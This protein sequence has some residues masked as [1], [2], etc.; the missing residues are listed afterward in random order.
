MRFATW[1]A[2]LSRDGPGLLLRDILS[3]K[4]PEV[5]AVVQGLLNIRP[6]VV[7]LTRVDHDLNGIAL[8]ALASRLAQ[9]GLEYPY[10]LA[11]AQNRGLPSGL[12]LD[13][14]GR[15][16]DPDDAHGYGRFSGDGAMA[17]LSRWPL[18]E[19]RDFSHFLWADMPDARL[20]TVPVAARA[21]HRLSSSAH[22]IVPVLLPDGGALHLL[23]WAATPPLFGARNPD[24]NHD[25]TAFWLHLLEGRLPM[26]PP[27]APFVLIGLP[28]LAPG[29]GDPSALRA[30]AV[31]PA[32]HPPAPGA[33]AMLAS[34]PAPLSLI[35]P[36]ADLHVTASGLHP[37]AAR[38]RMVWMTV[39]V[40]P[41]PP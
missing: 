28:N 15:R 17:V 40:D 1:N 2:D 26:A 3:G 38:H 13:G 30:L 39:T 27:S 35:Q 16:G 20:G 36:S 14:N 12:D 7:L 9:D 5:E 21:S 19:V 29:Q 34:G 23:A 4:D 18:G 8:N 11:P 32:L 41:A 31:H 22:W 24:R 25:E 10:R 6:D 33:S 37:E